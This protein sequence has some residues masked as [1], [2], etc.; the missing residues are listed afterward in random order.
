ELLEERAREG[1]ALAHQHDAFEGV[2]PTRQRVAIIEMIAEGLHLRLG[3]EA[4]PIRQAQRHA[5]IVVED[6]HPHHA[7]TLPARLSLAVAKLSASC[8]VG[9]GGDWQADER[10]CYNAEIGFMRR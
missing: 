8:K 6:C 7:H 2:E 10:R 9:N 1:R 4:L 5:L 3:M